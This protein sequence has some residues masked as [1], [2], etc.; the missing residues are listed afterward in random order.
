[1]FARAIIPEH[2]WQQ[3][4]AHVVRPGGEH[5]AFFLVG[6]AE[7]RGVT[8][9]LARETILVDDD[10]LESGFLLRPKLDAL[11]R[12]LNTATAKQ[13]ALVEVHNHPASDRHVAFSTIDLDGQRELVEYLADAGPGLPY[14]AL[15]LGDRSVDGLLWQGH[16]VEAVQMD[17]VRILGENLTRLTC[18]TWPSDPGEPPEPEMNR[19]VLALG[20][21]GQ[22]RLQR[23]RVVV[24]GAGGI[25]SAVGQ[26]LAHL[27]LRDVVLIDDDIV[28][29][30][31]LHRLIGASAADVGRP[32][33]EVLAEF[34]A[35]INSR[36]AAHAV[37]A[38]ARHVL[39]LLAAADVIIGCVDTDAARMMMN[40][41]AVAYMVPYIDCGVG[42]TVDEGRVVEAGGKVSVWTPGRPCSVC[43]RDFS[44]RVAAEELES[45]VEI[46][47]RRQHG[48]IAGADV[49]EPAIVSLNGTVAS[50]AVT[51][52]VA[53]VA[54]LRPSRH[55]TYYDMLEQRVGPRVVRRGAYCPVCELEGLGDRASVDR[56]GRIGL[57]S[58][59]PALS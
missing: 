19:Q 36:M 27:G 11:L 58:D 7:Q 48:Y 16:D 17:E 39:H 55:Y 26:Q 44:P 5:L 37:V 23:C 33:A 56:Y 52:F 49:P 31:N 34:M 2:L 42:V 24:V 30:S 18:S 40:E 8:T 35:R 59:V 1:M 10:D 28:E 21:D 51:E 57:P 20:T 46:D 32:K 53:L 15:V 50:L 29:Y 12:V 4:R 38:N 9:L 25:G 54:G 13:L 6:V 14:G 45:P 43:C 3:V 22:R 41:L 47:F